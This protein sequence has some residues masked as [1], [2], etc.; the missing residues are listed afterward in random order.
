MAEF[1]VRVL[2]ALWLA[3]ASSSTVSNAAESHSVPGDFA[4]I[5]AALGTALAEDTIL[6]APGVYSASSNG[7]TFP[8]N[9]D[10]C[11]EHVDGAH[12]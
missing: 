12:M 2:L 9:R 10:R 7:E 4:T 8:L 11:G 6:V 5:T 1:W 3:I